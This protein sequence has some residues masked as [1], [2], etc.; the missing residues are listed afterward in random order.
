MFANNSYFTNISP[1]D[2]KL[3]ACQALRDFFHEFGIPYHLNFNGLKEQSEKGTAFM[4]TVKHYGI[5]H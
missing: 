2:G 5:G 3:K 4:K 1:M